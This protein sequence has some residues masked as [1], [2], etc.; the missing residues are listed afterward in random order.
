MIIR[1]VIRYRS[2]IDADT[3]FVE[4]LNL[5]DQKIMRNVYRL[6]GRYLF[7]RPDRRAVMYSVLQR[8]DGGQDFLRCGVEAEF[9]KCERVIDQFF[10]GNSRKCTFIHSTPFDNQTQCENRLKSCRFRSMNAAR[11]QC[12]RGRREMLIRT[13]PK[14]G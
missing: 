8:G 9:A 12:I 5:T 2:D 10:H 11:G 7:R 13:G 4:I 14:R 3:G 6:K 1:A